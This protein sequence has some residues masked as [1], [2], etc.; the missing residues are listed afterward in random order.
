MDDVP[1][2]MKKNK[3]EKVELKETMEDESSEETAA[4]NVDSDDEA[5]ESGEANLI[6]FEAGDQE[7]DV[8][9]GNPGTRCMHVIEF[10]LTVK[11]SCCVLGFMSINGE[12]KRSN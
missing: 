5:L 4:D 12:Y 2:R 3:S 6:H 1:E 10:F 11:S 9:N 8:I 7:N